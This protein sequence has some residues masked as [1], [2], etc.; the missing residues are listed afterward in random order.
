M[1]LAVG[2]VVQ[3]A[4]EAFGNSNCSFKPVPIAGLSMGI[5]QDVE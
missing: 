5:S 4:S 3:D 2:V 1:Q